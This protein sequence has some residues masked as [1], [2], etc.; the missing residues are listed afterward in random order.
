MKAAILFLFV[1]FCVG[2]S[3]V[4]KTETAATVSNE[5]QSATAQQTVSDSALT[6]QDFGADG[7]AAQQKSPA[8][9]VEDLYARHKRDNAAILQTKN[10]ALLDRFFAKNLADLI[11]RDLTTHSDEVGVLD[12][13]PF[14]NA[15]DFDIKNFAV[16]PAKIENGKASVVASFTNFGNKESIVYALVKEKGA[17]KIADVRY[18]DNSS[19]LKYFKDDAQNQ[20]SANGSEEHFFSGTY[21]VGTTTCI[22]KPVKMAFEIRW[23]KGAGAMIFVFDGERD[24][25]FRY[26][27]EEKGDG[28]DA[29]VFDDDR[30]EI[31]KF[32]R[33][34]G[35]EM[36]VKKIN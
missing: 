19:L 26:L 31:G 33:A 16:A 9:V 23:A 21:Q 34:D 17:W 25:K 18:K 5:S 15:Q 10:R 3:S 32:I 13:D 36:P 24:G 30:F 8:A 11:W 4:I 28:R 7:A 22:V 6:A 29:F 35:K 20:S 2:C 12:F 14:Y 1:V 27:S